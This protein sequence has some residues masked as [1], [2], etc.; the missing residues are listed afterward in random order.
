MPLTRLGDLFL[1]IAS[2]SGSSTYYPRLLTLLCAFLQRAEI[3]QEFIFPR[4]TFRQ[5]W[6]TTVMTSQSPL[7]VELK[8][9]ISVLCLKLCFCLASVPSLFLFPYFPTT[10]FWTYY[11]S[12]SG[13][14]LGTQPEKVA[15][16]PTPGWYSAMW[17]AL[18]A[19]LCHRCFLSKH[20][21]EF[22]GSYGFCP[23]RVGRVPELPKTYPW[24]PV[25]KPLI[26]TQNLRQGK[27]I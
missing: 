2:T 17:T 26:L 7:Q 22:I 8:P 5:W 24:T 13:S 1:P 12:E 20:N 21:Q 10:S 14:T 15:D 9:P 19:A 27:K 25:S 11:L 23:E 16:H 3:A 6:M 4:K 18:Y